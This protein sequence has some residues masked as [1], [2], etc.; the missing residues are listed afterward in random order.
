M[1]R[2]DPVGANPK[3]NVERARRGI[4]RRRR[5]ARPT[6]GPTETRRLALIDDARHGSVRV[7]AGI[8][9][10]LAENV[11]RSLSRTVESRI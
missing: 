7:A 5:T 1:D 2:V 8:H 6:D 10:K 3:R 11:V 9:A 4:D